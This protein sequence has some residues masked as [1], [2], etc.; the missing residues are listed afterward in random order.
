[1]CLWEITQVFG[2]NNLVPTVT[3]SLLVDTRRYTLE[4]RVQNVTMSSMG[5]LR[6]T[7]A[8]AH[9]VTRLRPHSDERDKN[10]SHCHRGKCHTY[11]V[12][13]LRLQYGKL[14]RLPPIMGFVG[15]G[16]GLVIILA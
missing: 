15:S 4:M 11:I 5:V 2:K 12:I 13:D 7:R 8:R 1:M 3:C 9:R 6:D 10:H 14:R 16:P